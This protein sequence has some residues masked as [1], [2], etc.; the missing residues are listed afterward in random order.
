M[1]AARDW[2]LDLWS[3]PAKQTQGNPTFFFGVFGSDMAR[4]PNISVSIVS[5]M[6]SVSG[7]MVQT[8]C[9][10]LPPPKNGCKKIVSG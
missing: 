5:D 1:P 10:K 8:N 7:L 4:L 9:K 2:P 3:L 6:F